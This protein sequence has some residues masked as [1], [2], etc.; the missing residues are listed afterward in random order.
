[1]VK[2]VVL[3]VLYRCGLNDSQSVVTLL[4]VIKSIQSTIRLRIV[5]WDN[6]PIS[7]VTEADVVELRDVFDEVL[8]ESH[9]ENTPLS[10]IYNIV[11]QNHLNDDEFLLLLDQDT[12]LPG[13]FLNIFCDELIEHP[14]CDLF[15]PIIK[16]DG[17]IVSPVWF[18]FGWG[19][20]WKM[21]T[22]KGLISSRWK[23]AINSGMFVSA[24]YA[25]YDF[26]GYDER[27]H[28]Y[29]TDTDFMLKFADARQYFDVMPVILT[30]DLSFNSASPIER[31]AKFRTMR[32]ANSIIYSRMGWVKRLISVLV[33][34]LVSII[35]AVR[36]RDVRYVFFVGHY[37]RF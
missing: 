21:T 4:N 36:Y 25:R 26:L 8:Y 23:V 37:D 35:Y 10:K 31:L 27:L 28:F 12:S 9:P 20:K 11:I 1:M 33:M 18:F 2:L 15:L 32:T 19:R 7:C 6:S 13:D 30:H 17:V 22:I 34:A 14:D 16:S 24:K 29:G 5:L 3:V